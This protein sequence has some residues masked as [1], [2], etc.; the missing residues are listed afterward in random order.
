MRVFMNIA[1][2]EFLEEFQT[3]SKRLPKKEIQ[4]VQ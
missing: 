4:P 3:R 2:M 1:L